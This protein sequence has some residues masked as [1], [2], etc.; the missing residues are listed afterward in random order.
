MQQ[1]TGAGNK[2]VALS[3]GVT[4]RTPVQPGRR[5]RHMGT[6]LESQVDGARWRGSTLAALQYLARKADDNTGIVRDEGLQQIAE[7]LGL[8]WK[9]TKVIMQ[10]LRNGGVVE[11]IKR[12]GGRQKNTYRLHLTTDDNT[13]PGAD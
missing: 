4:V 8:S 11:T 10:A 7:F 3:Y 1:R 2:G 6:R 12:G 9:R 5:A 13:D